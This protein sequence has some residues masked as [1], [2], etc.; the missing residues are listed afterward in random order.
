MS[1]PS[2]T[3]LQLFGRVVRQHREG[4]GYTQLELAKRG[5]WQQSFINE[6]ETGKRNVTFHTI[7]RFARV[8]NVK[9]SALFEL[10][11]TRPELYPGHERDG[12]T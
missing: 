3:A 11:D 5:G 4:L 6:V 10:V 9:A 7:L 12:H 8:F 1:T 2:E